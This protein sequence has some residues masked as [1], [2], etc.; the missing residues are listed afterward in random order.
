MKSIIKLILSFF[1]I[2]GSADIFACDYP[3]KISIPDGNSATKLEMVTAMNNVK[4]YNKAIEDFQSCIEKEE[5]SSLAL[6]KINKQFTKE[7]GTNIQEL[8]TRKFDA[9]DKDKEK[10]SAEFNAQVRVF[11]AKGN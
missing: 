4:A 10:T 9:A 1:L 3:E 7:V 2:L 8:T 6:L 5:Q 11:N